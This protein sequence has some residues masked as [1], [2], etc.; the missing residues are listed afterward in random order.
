MSEQVRTRQTSV[1]GHI[2]SAAFGQGYR[3]AIKGY[4]WRTLDNMRGNRKKTAIDTMWDYERG[5]YFAAYLRGEGMPFIAL[6]EGRRVSYRAASLFSKAIR[7]YA[8]T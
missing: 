6:K 8:I 4:P 5:R 2:S 7:C 3:D 1:T